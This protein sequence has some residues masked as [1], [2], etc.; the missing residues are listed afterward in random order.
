MVNNAWFSALR[1][2]SYFKRG[3]GN[4]GIPISVAQFVI[5]LYTL[6]LVRIPNVVQMFPTIAT[7]ALAGVAIVSPI[8]VA[9]GYLDYHPTSATLS[10]DNRLVSRANPY[11]V[12]MARSIM[13]IADPKLT[14]EE[15]KRTVDSVLEKWL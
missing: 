2:W 5:I 10:M 6:L 15:K 13:I 12:D 1:L 14:P 9:I 7:F 4:L 3:Y 11:F 8:A